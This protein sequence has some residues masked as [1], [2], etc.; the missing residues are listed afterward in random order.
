MNRQIGD[1]KS[2]EKN[3]MVLVVRSVVYLLVAGK[4][5]ADGE[6]GVG[7]G[8]VIGWLGRGFVIG[9]LG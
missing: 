2:G 1:R 9:L 3:G 8:L 6:T 5:R 4:G 7:L